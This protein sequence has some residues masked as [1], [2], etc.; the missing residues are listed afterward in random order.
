MQTYQPAL[1]KIPHPHTSAGTDCP[2]TAFHYPA[3]PSVIVGIPH[4]ETGKYK[5]KVHGQITVIE[6]LVKRTRRKALE[7]MIPYHHKGRH[8]PKAVL[9][10]IVRLRV[11]EHRRDGI[12]FHSH[13]LL[14]F[15][16][17]NLG[18]YTKPTRRGRQPS[19]YAGGMG[20]RTTGRNLRQEPR[21][22]LPRR[23][24]PPDL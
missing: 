4:H 10:R 22:S 5:E 24:R 9:Y 19:R 18:R 2:V 16:R 13:V 7:H 21:Q 6:M 1:E 12:I 11:L 17:H 8:S 15:V 23:N 14:R 20:L 3:L